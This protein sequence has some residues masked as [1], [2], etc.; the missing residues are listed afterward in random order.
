MAGQYLQ[1]L[2]SKLA[3]EEIIAKIKDGLTPEA[4]AIAC[5]ELQGRGIE[6]P[7]IEE[8]PIEPEELPYP[9]DWVILARDLEP[10]EAHILASCLAEAGID[11]DPGAVSAVQLWPTIA[12]GSAKIRVRQSQLTEAQRILQAFRRGELAL[13]DDFD[14]GKTDGDSNDPS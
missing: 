5:R 8:E 9:G 6:P 3:D 14:T 7:P 10:T 13:D 2:F 1:D 11:T 4:Y 12:L